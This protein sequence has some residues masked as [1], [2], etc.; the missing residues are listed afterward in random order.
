MQNKTIGINLVRVVNF[1]VNKNGVYAIKVTA[2][3]DKLQDLRMELDGEYFREVPA[4]KSIQKFDVAAAW[5]GD[6]LNGLSQVNIF[7]VNLEAGEHKLEFYLRDRHV[8]DVYPSILQQIKEEW[9]NRIECE[10]RYLGGIIDDNSHSVLV[11]TL[12]L[13]LQSQKRNRQPWINLIFQSLPVRS[14]EYQASL[15]WRDKWD[16]DD[17]KIIVDGR[18]RQAETAFRYE[19]IHHTIPG[20]LEHNDNNTIITNLSRGNHRVEFWADCQPTLK[21]LC[22]NFNDHSIKPKLSYHR[23]RKHNQVLKEYPNAK[24]LDFYV[25]RYGEEMHLGF[26]HPGAA[27]IIY[28]PEYNPAS[29]TLKDDYLAYFWNGAVWEKVDT[30]GLEHDSAKEIDMGINFAGDQFDVSEPLPDGWKAFFIG[31]TW[32]ASHLPIWHI[33]SNWLIYKLK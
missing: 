18:T 6:K 5:N 17:L 15:A 22:I 26:E 21:H 13:D 25:E 8:T 31:T 2:G 4:L 23:Q 7:F 28:D 16:G 1:S 19:W 27:I 32:R 10:Y 29:E 14:I 11:A 30:Y 33:D 9:K 20:Q 3:C 12:D 24:L